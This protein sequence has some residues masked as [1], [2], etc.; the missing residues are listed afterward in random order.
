MEKLQNLNVL[1]VD[2]DKM[3]VELTRAVLSKYFKNVYS[4]YD[5]QEA[6]EMYKK[7]PED[8]HVIISD[9]NMPNMNGGVFSKEILKI[10]KE[11]CF[12]LFSIDNKEDEANEI[13]VNFLPK[14]L[15]L[16]YLDYISAEYHQEKI[17]V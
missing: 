9:Y 15:E 13:G 8:F 14:P 12:F 17:A 1:F 11:Q 16:D 6:L 3:T 4:A 5:G 7:N 2:D 10:N